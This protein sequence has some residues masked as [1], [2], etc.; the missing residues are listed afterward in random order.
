MA[1]TDFEP[2]DHIRLMREAAVR[3]GL[4]G[5]RGGHASSAPARGQ[6]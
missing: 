1:R 2:G 3:E 5:H 6:R 4:G